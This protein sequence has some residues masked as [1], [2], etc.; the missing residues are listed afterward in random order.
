MSLAMHNAVNGHRGNPDQSGQCVLRHAANVFGPDVKDLLGCQ[1]RARVRRPTRNTRQTA[2]AF[3]PAV[4]HVVGC[5]AEEQVIRTHARRIVAVMT[6]EHAVGDRAVDQFPRY[7][8]GECGSSLG[9]EQAA[10]SSLIE[11]SSPRPAAVAF[12]NVAPEPFGQRAGM[13]GVLVH[14]TDDF[15]T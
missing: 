11:V 5:G 3:M 7:S 13:G 14:S 4:A 6:G 2:A 8:V 12:S 15:I 1:L 10:V 9:D